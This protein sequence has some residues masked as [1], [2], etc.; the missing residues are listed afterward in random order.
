MRAVRYHGPGDLRVDDLPEPQPGCGE[1]LLR[2]EAVGVCGTDTH[3]VDGEF[4][5]AAPV[6]LGHEVCGTVVGVGPGVDDPKPGDLVTVE[7]HRYC[8][9][10]PYCRLGAE[11]LCLRKQ[12]YGVNLDGGMAELMVVPARVAYRLP[13]GTP[14]RVGAL[15]EPVACCMHGMDRL[16]P[17]SGL[18]LLVFGCGPAGAVLVALARLS[19]LGPIVV[20]EGRASRRRLAERMGA[21]VVLDAADGGYREQART[22]A[23]ELGF[24]YLVDAVGSPAILEDAVTLAARGGRILVF[25]VA[26]PDAVARIRPQEVFAKELTVLGSVIN[27]YTH[28]R[29]VGLLPRLGL[30]RL[31]VATF[32]LE[33]AAAALDAQR[34]GV[35]DKVQLAPEPT[36]H[37]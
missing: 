5:A 6:T 29:A 16:A 33:R 37:P 25:G 34:G 32:P 35:P 23:G 7:P 24:P 8:G 21:D 10:C 28:H 1:V 4:P 14:P 12:A 9:R 22:A 36:V 20:V 15:T 30:D 17:L 18:P 13:P 19:G 11:H 31:D 3:I 27:P 26:A 2:P